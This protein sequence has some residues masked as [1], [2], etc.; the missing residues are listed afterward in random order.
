LNRPKSETSDFG[1]GEVDS[2]H[3]TATPETLLLQP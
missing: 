2:W 3:G 1:W